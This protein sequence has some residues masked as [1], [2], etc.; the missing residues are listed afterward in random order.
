MPQGQPH[1][2]CFVGP[3]AL[4]EL[5]EYLGLLRAEPYRQNDV[6]GMPLMGFD[7]PL[8]DRIRVLSSHVLMMTYREC[9]RKKPR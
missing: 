5:R 6:D 4:G 9:L 3:F 2:F 8:V 7:R 1:G